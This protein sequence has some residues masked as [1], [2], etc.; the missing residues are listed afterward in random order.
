MIVDAEIRER[1]SHFCTVSKLT[2]EK[3]ANLALR[4]MLERCEQD[5][6]LKSKMDR[7]KALKEELA[8][9]GQ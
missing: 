5:P 2:Q 4:E 3:A 7:V 9:I 1:L 8:S 6:T